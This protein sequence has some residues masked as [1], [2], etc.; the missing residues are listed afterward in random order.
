[1]GLFLQADVGPSVADGETAVS[2]KRKKKGTTRKTRAAKSPKK[3]D[4]APKAEPQVKSLHLTFGTEVRR[5]RTELGMSLVKLA[6]L[7]GLTPNYI[8][9]LERGKVNPALST[10]TL[11]AA[12]LGAQLRELIGNIDKLSPSAVRMGHLLDQAPPQIQKG[13]L[14]LLRGSVKLATKPKPGDDET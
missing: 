7:S 12:G 1:L 8:G 5:R 11:I 13:V 2:A 14:V 4:P 3:P 9:K 6:M 10:M